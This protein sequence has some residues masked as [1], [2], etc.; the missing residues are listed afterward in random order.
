M[1]SNLFQ[2]LQNEVALL[3]TQGSAPTSTLQ[4]GTWK[5]SDPDP[6]FFPWPQ[7]TDAVQQPL[8]HPARKAS[9]TRMHVLVRAHSHVPDVVKLHC[10]C[11]R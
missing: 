4:V 9:S 10:E 11:L 1:I 3:G 2:V 8:L 6:V 7:V 5:L